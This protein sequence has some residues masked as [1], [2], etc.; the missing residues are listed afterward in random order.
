MVYYI[1]LMQITKEGML[2]LNNKMKFQV[3]LP[4][5]MHKKELVMLDMPVEKLQFLLEVV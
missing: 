2:K 5:F 1:K 4:K 3:L